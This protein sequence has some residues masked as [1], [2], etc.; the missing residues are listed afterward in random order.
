MNPTFLKCESGNDI[1]DKGYCSEEKCQSCCPHNERDHGI[2]L[3][4]AHEQDP[5]E[6]IDRAMDA[7]EAANE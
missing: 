3:V 6:A 4:C 7:W 5:G 2:C 1:D